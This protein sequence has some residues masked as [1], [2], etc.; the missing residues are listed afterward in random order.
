[1]ADRFTAFTFIDRITTLE[2][3]R[4]AAGN[5]L[6]PAAIPEFPSCL[7]AESLGQLAVWV[8]M[9]QLDFKLR[10]VAGLA[11]ETRFHRDVTPGQRLDLSI[12]IESCDEHAIS[13]DGWVHVDGTE[14][15]E[16]KHC[17]G[18][19]LPADDFDDAGEVRPYFSLL[20]EA[21]A[22]P[23][24]FPGVAWPEV[25]LHDRAPGRSLH[26]A[27][28]IPHTAPYF[29]DHFPRR[30]V[31][32]ATL[33]LGTQIRL[34]VELAGELGDWHTAAELIASRTTDVKMR[35]WILP[36]QTVELGIELE[37]RVD[38]AATAKL[39]SRLNGRQL[40]FARVDITPRVAA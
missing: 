13:Y 19:M 21:G 37:P 25:V 31:F 12:E 6:V 36:G 29:G 34:A 10:P 26:A 30:P 16:L 3:G 17:V 9:A 18:P 40:S 2:P 28:H 35:S 22:T 1:M 23:G 4:S 38:D 14:V 8:A 33:L 27:M 11:A 5:F 39:T 32:P 20:R 15:L 7:V 24:R